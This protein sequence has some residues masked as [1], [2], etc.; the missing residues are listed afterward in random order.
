MEDETME[1]NILEMVTQALTENRISEGLQQS[2][3]YRLAKEEEGKLYDKLISDLTDEQKNRLD[4]FI[5][6]TTY[7][8]SLWETYAYQ[9]G[10]KDLMSFLQS[11]LY[12]EQKKEK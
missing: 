5:D 2:E 10:M 9:R 3:K 11:L 12:Q 8:I 1:D 4:D 7:T 6:G